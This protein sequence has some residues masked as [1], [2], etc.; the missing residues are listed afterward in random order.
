MIDPILNSLWTHYVDPHEVCHKLY[1]CPKE[2]FK[3]NVTE[4][5]H[6]I[7]KDK[8]NKEWEKATNRKSFKI[9]HISDLHPDFF[10]TPGAEAL[11]S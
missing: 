8:P 9:M 5:L 6:N 4:E 7:V 10:Y 1:L 3:R 11:C 2:Y